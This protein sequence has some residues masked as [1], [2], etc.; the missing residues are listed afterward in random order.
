MASF[1]PARLSLLLLLCLLA[2]CGPAPA[3][4]TPGLPAQP[5]PA[6]PTVATPAPTAA[7]RPTAIP[8]VTTI[9]EAPAPPSAL[10]LWAVAAGPQ[11]DAVRR[12][13]ADLGQAV[14]LEVVVVG[15]SADGLVADIRADALAGLPPPDLI[16][17]GQDEL[18]LLQ[19]EGLL[20]E[21]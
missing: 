2:A 16:W 17:G 4:P 18:A 1:S 21:A 8:P 6:R 7:P 19:G 13:V 5:A 12:L 9:A 14:G 3:A 15:K 10:R 20:Q 11:L